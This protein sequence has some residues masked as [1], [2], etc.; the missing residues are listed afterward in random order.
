MAFVGVTLAGTGSIFLYM[1]Q[2]P[3]G[4]VI[5]LRPRENKIT[6]GGGATY[7]AGLSTMNFGARGLL[8]STK[9]EGSRNNSYLIQ[10]IVDFEMRRWDLF[11]TDGKA[12]DEGL[13]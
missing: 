8:A 9:F 5:S 12:S 1:H 7:K 4:L 13:V 11:D 10:E 2:P 6:V 3:A